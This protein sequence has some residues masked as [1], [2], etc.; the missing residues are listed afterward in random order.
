MDDLIQRYTNAWASHD[1]DAI[2]ALHT[3]DTRFHAHIGQ[4]P[5]VGKMAVRQ[6]FAE[7]FA[8]FPDLAFEQVSLKTTADFWAVEWKMS[9]T[10]AGTDH[11]FE[12]DL[13]D[14]ITVEDGLVKSKDSYIDAVSM[15]AQLGLVAVQ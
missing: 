13:V 5:A 9:G 3:E 10:L 1:P 8:Q 15:Q 12:V 14:L 2:V 6:A 7:L 4:E 11:T